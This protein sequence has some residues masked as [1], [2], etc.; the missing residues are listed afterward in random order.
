MLV[1]RILPYLVKDQVHI[2]ARTAQMSKEKWQSIITLRTQRSVNTKH[3]KNFKSFFKCSRRNHQRLWWNWLSWGLTHCVGQETQ[4]IDWWKSVL[5][6]DESKFE[7]SG[8]NRRVFVRRRIGERMIS[9]CVVPT[10]K[11]GGWGVMVCGGGGLLLTLLVI[12]LEFKVHLINQ[13][14]YYSDTPSH[15]V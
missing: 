12:Y 8:S 2:M 9:A 1:Y 14:G 4:A 13:H 15:L 10:V 7:I 5:W 3:F 11:H 6:S